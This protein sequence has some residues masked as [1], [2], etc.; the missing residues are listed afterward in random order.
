MGCLTLD[1]QLYPYEILNLGRGQ[2]YPVE[3]FIFFIENATGILAIKKMMPMAKGDVLIT[4]ADI[5]KAKMLI[6]YNPNDI[7]RGWYK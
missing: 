6:G 2:P 7:F 5:N 3:Q 1:F 4:Y